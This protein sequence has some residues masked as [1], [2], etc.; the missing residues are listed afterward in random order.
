MALAGETVVEPKIVEVAMTSSPEFDRAVPRGLQ[1]AASWA[2]RLI[3]I[4]I[5]LYGL[6]WLTRYLSEV[7][8][9]LAVAILL[10]AM[11][12]PLTNRLRKW[13]VPRGLAA[14]ISMALGLIV[15][16]GALT[17]IG[18]QIASQAP[19]LG[20]SVASG[21]NQFIGWLKTGPLHIS[22]SWFNVDEWGKRIQTFVV[23]SRST[24]ATYAS[25]IGAQ[26]GHFIAGLAIALFS[27]FFFLFEGRVVFDFLLKFVPRHARARVDEAAQ[28]GWTSLSHYVRAVVLVALVDAIGVLGG[29]LILGVP[30]APALAA[31]VFIGAFVP[32]VGAF[33]SGFVA[34]I[35][36]LVALGWLKAVIML[37]IIVAVMQIEAHGLQP[38]LLGRAVHLHPLAVIFGIAI[39]VIVGGIVGALMSI[40]LLAFTKTFIAELAKSSS[41]LEPAGEAFG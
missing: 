26:V 38:F 20:K 29:A 32:I 41:G 16:A 39:G 2:W 19:D 10:A 11:L 6:G 3:V 27:L 12:T 30:L 15:I 13:G 9:P 21:F 8:V 36:A 23:N 35:V 4:A 31:L 18:T 37:A 34:V 22:Q 33:L 25:E 14:A 7:V 28:Q 1:V 17:L 24:I 40:P 5:V